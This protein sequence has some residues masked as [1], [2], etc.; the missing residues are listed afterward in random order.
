MLPSKSERKMIL[1]EKKL[2]E[3]NLDPAPVTFPVT[4]WNR[5]LHD[6]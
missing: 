6:I 2:L 4:V 1:E 3:M 5:N